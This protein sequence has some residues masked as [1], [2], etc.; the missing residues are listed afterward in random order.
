M[1][2]LSS[3]NKTHIQQLCIDV[4]GTS[5]Q[6]RYMTFTA[7]CIMVRRKVMEMEPLTDGFLPVS[8][9]NSRPDTY[10]NY[11]LYE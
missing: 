5:V 3:V 1:I 7:D 4:K 6:S 11:N 10:I 2:L 8:M 9:P